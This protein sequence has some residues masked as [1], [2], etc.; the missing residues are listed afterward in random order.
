VLGLA[1]ILVV[2]SLATFLAPATLFYLSAALG[3]GIDAIEVLN[4]P[5]IG[6]GLFYVTV[7]LVT[8]SLVLSLLAATRRTNVS[9]QSHPMNLPVFG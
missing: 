1:V 6:K 7:I 9:E 5:V 4:Y 2:G 8:L 3:L